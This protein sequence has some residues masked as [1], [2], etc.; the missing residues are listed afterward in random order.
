MGRGDIEAALQS[1]VADA[2]AA[3]LASARAGDAA[4]HPEPALW[5]A[6]PNVKSESALPDG[7]TAAWALIWRR[8]LLV[9]WL[10]DSRVVLCRWEGASNPVPDPGIPCTAGGSKPGERVGSSC[11]SCAGQHN[12]EPVQSNRPGG[13]A[14]ADSS[15][16]P[17]KIG[18]KRLRAVALTEDHS[19]GRP[20]ERARI[21]A[22]GGSV[23]TALNDALHLFCLCQHSLLERPRTVS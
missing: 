15:S 13:A 22:A 17:G 11:T 23:S 4:T 18:S 7:T 14:T 9:A 8:E 21:L 1:A 10:G 16:A 6:N 12:P 3:L 19:P 2:D 20:D 5:G